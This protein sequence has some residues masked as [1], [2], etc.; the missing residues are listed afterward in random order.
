MNIGIDFG[1]TYSTFSRYDKNADTLEFISLEESGGASIPSVVSVSKKGE[2]FF[3]F[4]AK[5]KIGKKSQRIFEA[6]KML[7]VETDREILR[8]RGYDNEFTPKAV[9]EKY[10]NYILGAISVRYNNG[11]PIED[12]VICMPEVWSNELKHI[13]GRGILQKMLSTDSEGNRRR[14]RV[15]T[16]PEAASAFFAYNYEKET[17]NKFDGHLLL[18]DYGGGTLDLSLTE[19]RPV[20]ENAMEISYCNS[21]GAGDNHTC[22]GGK[23]KIG[24]AGIAFM[25][26]VVL[27]AIQDS[28][29]IEDKDD[30]DYSSPQFQEAVKELESAL[31]SKTIDIRNK[32]DTIGCYSDIVTDIDDLLDDELFFTSVTFD[33]S[34]IEV[35]YKHMVDAYRDN[36]EE[37]LGSSVNE[38]NEYIIDNLGFDPCE[39]EAATKNNF[40]LAI[41]GGF[42]SF[43]LVQKQ[44]AEMYNISA[45]SSA[46]LRL[47]NIPDD[48]KETAISLGAALIV[49]KKVVLQSVARYSIG[50]PVR[51]AKSDVSIPAYAIKRSDIIDSSKVYRC[52]LTD[53]GEDI[54]VSNIKN[55][56]TH[57]VINKTGKEKNGIK[58]PLKPEMINQILYG[59]KE[60]DADIWH[61][62]FSMDESGIITFHAIPTELSDSAQSEVTV[63][64]DTYS[65]LFEM[66]ATTK[67]DLI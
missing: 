25:Q 49:E 35:T 3:G 23:N 19:V 50:I 7:L 16:E 32:F 37:A 14:V 31:K 17:G 58:M 1:S 27:R 46:D 34:E 38:M 51:T 64:L 42:S 55:S 30:I 2:S 43:I 5:D 65:N 52:K 11:E 47:K 8:S 39:P 26:D 48:K 63:P 13:D 18:I 9:A 41:V 33:D 21:G 60:D 66:T 40:K 29:E 59:V 45:D 24:C 54:F 15:V 67:D 62:G 20:N 4:A 56:L 44:I 22:E 61:I 10:L 12:V 36:I 6:F 53:D 28:D 57:F